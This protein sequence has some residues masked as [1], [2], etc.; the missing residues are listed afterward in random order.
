MEIKF[1]GIAK[2]LVGNNKLMIDAPQSIATVGDIKNWLSQH[3]PSLQS[4]QS[5]AIA[6]DAEYANDTTIIYDNSEI[7]VLPP[8]SGG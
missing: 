1:F 2:E 7:A 8:V 5:Y 6:V 3:Y 4:L